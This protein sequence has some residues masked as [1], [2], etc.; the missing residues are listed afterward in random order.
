VSVTSVRRTDEHTE[1]FVNNR[2]VRISRETADGA[3]IK[4]AANI[5]EDFHLFGPRGEPI[6]NH[7]AMRIHRDERFTAISGHDVS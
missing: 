3:E 5:P 6:A 1:I 2:P 4:R 7:E